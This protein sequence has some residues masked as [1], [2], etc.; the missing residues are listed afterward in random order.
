MIVNISIVIIIII[1]IVVYH[2]W[3]R[4]EGVVN[5]GGL[6]THPCLDYRLVTRLKENRKEAFWAG[7]GLG[8]VTAAWLDSN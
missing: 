5:G 8:L 6:T 7:L 2:G 1:I 3:E 4:V